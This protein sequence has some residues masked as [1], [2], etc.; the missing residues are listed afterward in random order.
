MEMAPLSQGYKCVSGHSWQRE[1]VAP[2]GLKHN[3][4]PE[5]CFHTGGFDLTAELV[6]VPQA[7]KDQESSNGLALCLREESWKACQH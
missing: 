3:D 6:R 5:P 7:K 1:E 4:T 2:R